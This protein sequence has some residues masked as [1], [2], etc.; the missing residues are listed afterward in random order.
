MAKDIYALSYKQKLRW[1]EVIYMFILTV[2]VPYC[3][4]L[5]QFDKQ[6]HALSYVFVNMTSIPV[7][8]LFYR[9]YLEMI[10][11]KKK[12]ILSAVLFPVY[13]VIYEL[14]I[15]LFG[16]ITI[17]YFLFIPKSYR[18]NYDQ[19]HPERFDHIH[20]FVGYTLL[21]L[22]TASA[23]SVVRLF[24]EKQNELHAMQYAQVQLELENLRSQVQPHFFFN[25]LNNL[26]NLSIQGSPKAPEM[27]ASLSAIMRYVIYQTQEK[28][29]L[30]KEIDFMRNYFE[31]ER[32]RHTDPDLIDFQ[33]QGDPEGIEIAPLLFLPLIENCFKHALQQDILENQVKIILLIDN[34]EL[35]FQTSNKI[36]HKPADT[37]NG[38]IG[39]SNV[40]KRLELLYGSRQQVDITKESDNYMVTI[41][42]QL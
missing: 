10:V 39:L 16:Y 1:S 23:M 5:Q 28:V 9:G 31:L 41:S 32:I 19:G 3:F 33:V 42:I 34:D 6:S 18:D 26:Y 14:Y 35:V 36:I 20:Q 11:F 13:L 12:W 40:R 7:I 4:G 38:G 21:I 37:N 29:L 27:I 24:F 30:T 17:H 2:L 15:R 8:I 25:T 22:V